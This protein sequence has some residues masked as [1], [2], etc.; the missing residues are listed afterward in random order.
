MYGSPE[1]VVEMD[2]VKDLQQILCLSYSS[3]VY[4]ILL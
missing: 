3:L 1:I 4:S 2:I